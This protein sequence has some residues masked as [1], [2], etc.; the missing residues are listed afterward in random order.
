[1]DYNDMIGQIMPLVRDGNLNAPFIISRKDDDWFVS[2]CKSA[3]SAQDYLTSIRQ[4]DPYAVKFNSVDFSRGSLPFVFE[5]VLAA[6]LRAEYETIPLDAENHSELRAIINFV[7]DNFAMFSMDAAKYLTQYDRPFS[8]IAGMIPFNMKDD[9]SPFGFNEKRLQDAIDVIE[10][11]ITE[12]INRPKD[13]DGAMVNPNEGFTSQLSR[14]DLVDLLEAYD[15][16][17]QDANDEQRYREGWYPVCINE[18]YD[19][20]YRLLQELMEAPEPEENI[21]YERES[22]APVIVRGTENPVHRQ[23]PK[24]PETD[25][26]SLLGRLDKANTKA[27]KADAEPKEPKKRPPGRDKSGLE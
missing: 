21:P 23:K 9:N 5:K 19:N 3:E 7:E 8:A 4:H 12:L 6:R 17:I 16:Y 18:F 20:E 1:M 13:I 26:Q 27:A 22:G 15:H 25:R 24:K 2:Y 11:K 14:A 10:N